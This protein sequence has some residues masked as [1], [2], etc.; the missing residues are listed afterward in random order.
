M[1][2]RLGGKPVEE[3][4]Q[5]ICDSKQNILM[6]RKC[7]REDYQILIIISVC[8]LDDGHLLSLQISTF[9]FCIKLIHIL[10]YYILFTNAFQE[11][12]ASDEFHCSKGKGKYAVVKNR[13]G[14]FLTSI[15][16]RIYLCQGMQLRPCKQTSAKKNF[17]FNIF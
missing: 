3:C 9:S 5:I 15:F 8:I 13:S 7:L 2:K 4:W 10:F 12:L 1:F 16:H 17:Y 14:Y 6:I 11:L